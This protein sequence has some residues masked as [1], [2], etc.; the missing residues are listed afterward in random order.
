MRFKTISVL[1]FLCVLTASA[2]L[3]DDTPPVFAEGERPFGLPFAD[4]PGPTTWLL[5]Q[6]YGNTTG[7]YASRVTQY[8]RGQGIHF[9][10][11][12]SAPCGTVLVAIAD[13]VVSGADGPW[14]SAPHN[15]M[16]DYPNGYSSMYGHL[17]QRPNWQRGQAVKRGQPVALSGDPDETCYSRP[18]LHLEIRSRSY[19]RWYNPVLFIEADWDTLA[20]TGSFSRGFE[21]DLDNPRRW[22]LLADQ[23]EAEAG[24]PFLNNFLRPWPPAPTSQR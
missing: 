8:S 21:K 4:P 5:A 12:F 17:L 6:A 9:G 24:G 23:P 15:L 10:I 7:A 16:I 13:G 19:T 14:G 18:H 2:A 22:Q 20:L 3:E 11:D 1:V